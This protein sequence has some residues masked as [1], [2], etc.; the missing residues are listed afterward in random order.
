MSPAKAIFGTRI[1]FQKLRSDSPDF[2]DDDLKLREL[3]TSPQGEGNPVQVCGAPKLGFSTA[4][5]TNTVLSLICLAWLP[6]FPSKHRRLSSRLKDSG[7]G[8]DKREIRS[9]DVSEGFFKIVCIVQMGKL[10]SR[11][12]SISRSGL[13]RP[14]MAELEWDLVL[15]LD[16]QPAPLPWLPREAWQA[17]A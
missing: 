10:R 4:P 7:L 14:S 1:H 5:I 8:G 6:G 17:V 11:E 16:A 9:M 2:M 13:P 3:R 12:I 15:P